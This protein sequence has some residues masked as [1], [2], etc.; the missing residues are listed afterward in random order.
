M[1][2]RLLG[3]IASCGLD[4]DTGFDDWMAKHHDLHMA[5]PRRIRHGISADFQT[6]KSMVC[7]LKSG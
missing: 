5:A 2:A 3:R 6:L 4:P 1:S 7:V